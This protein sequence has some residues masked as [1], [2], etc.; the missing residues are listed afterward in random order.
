M[1]KRN[2][3]HLVFC[4]AVFVWSAVSTA[5]A[6]TVSGKWYGIGNPDIVGASNS[7]LCELI[8]TQNG[9]SVT[10]YFNYFFRNGYFS[11]KLVGR[12]DA[13]QRLLILKPVPILY[14]LSSNVGTG[15]DCIMTGVFKLKVARAESTLIR[16]V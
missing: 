6:Q 7:Y 1:G 14:H 5:Q 13:S 4:I 8:I 15:V 3:K 10:G 2:Y 11:N 16:H 9:S 12:Y